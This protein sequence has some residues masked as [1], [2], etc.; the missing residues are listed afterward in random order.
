MANFSRHIFN[1]SII[2]VLLGSILGCGRKEEPIDV[3]SRLTDMSQLELARMTV[4][5]VGMISDRDIHEANTLAGKAEALIDAVKIGKRIG[6][7]SY[8]TYVTA[9]IDL[10]DLHQEDV[11]IDRKNGSAKIKLPPVQI[12]IDGRDPQLR[13]E[14]YR[15]TGLRSEIKPEERAA[16]KSQM[17]AEAKGEIL[18]RAETSSQ[19]RVA[20][21]YKA[22]TWFTRLLENWGYKAE[23]RF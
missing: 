1:T 21:E 18:K 14:H 6:V 11:E 23:V 7:Y 20:A 15:V 2:L 12:R 16:L 4:E 17:A 5:K 3:Y 19:L 10:N 22:K 13:E 8:D 9:Y